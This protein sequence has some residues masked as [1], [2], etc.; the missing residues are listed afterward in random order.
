LTD[1]DA[2]VSSARRL[3]DDAR[4]SGTSIVAMSGSD[5]AD[6]TGFALL[7]RKSD[8]QSL[9]AAVEHVSKMGIAA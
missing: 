8:R 4:L 3:L 5:E 7:V 6:G 9:I 1:I 2:D